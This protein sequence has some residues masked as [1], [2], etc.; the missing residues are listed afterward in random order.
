[1]KWTDNANNNVI[2]R[3]AGFMEMHKLHFRLEGPDRKDVCLF[4]QLFL[5]MKVNL[6]ATVLWKKNSSF[7]FKPV[8][9][10]F[11][12]STF[13]LHL[14]FFQSTIPFVPW[15]YLCPHNILFDSMYKNN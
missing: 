4:F 1:M 6:K 2:V 9:S 3:Y 13:M 10:P 11:H 15:T 14:Q 5:L 7:S 12:S 8:Q